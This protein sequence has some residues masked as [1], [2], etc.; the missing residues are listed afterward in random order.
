[1]QVQS[2]VKDSLEILSQ[3]FSHSVVV[4]RSV[5]LDFVQN[6]SNQKQSAF[7]VR[8]TYLF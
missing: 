2:V 4:F 6:A 3:N 7:S 5:F 8:N 1:M